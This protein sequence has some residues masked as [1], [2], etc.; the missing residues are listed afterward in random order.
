M[1]K[2]MNLAFAGSPGASHSDFVPLEML[3][4]PFIP[5]QL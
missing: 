5:Q 4:Q 1:E 3:L 2:C